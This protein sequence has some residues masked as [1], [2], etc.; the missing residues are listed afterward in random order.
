MRDPRITNLAR[1]LVGY[2]VDVREG[3]TCVIRAPTTAEPLVGAVYEEVLKAGA[4][5]L[6]TL[7]FAGQSSAYFRHASDAELEWISS[8]LWRTISSL[9]I[10]PS[11][12]SSE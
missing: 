1:I 12:I 7:G 8:A 3:E 2:S 10:M 5:P 11:T 9:S 6:V 4:H